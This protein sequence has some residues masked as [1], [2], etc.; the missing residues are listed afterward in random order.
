[1]IAI[2]FKDAQSHGTL[3]VSTGLFLVDRIT[4]RLVIQPSKKRK[5]C[6]GYPNISLGPGILWLIIILMV[7]MHELKNQCKKHRESNVGLIRT[8]PKSNIRILCFTSILLDNK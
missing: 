5:N 6:H 8:I 4:L 2:N 3:Q 7:T 1:M